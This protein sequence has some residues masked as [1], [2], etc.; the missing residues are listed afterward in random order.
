MVSVFGKIMHAEFALCKNYDFARL[1]YDRIGTYSANFSSICAGRRIQFE[2]KSQAEIRSAGYRPA[3]PTVART[4]TTI[5]MIKWR[6]NWMKHQSFHT[7][8]VKWS[9]VCWHKGHLRYLTD[10]IRNCGLSFLLPL[11]TKEKKL[12]KPIAVRFASPN[13]SPTETHKHD[14]SQSPSLSDTMATY[15]QPPDILMTSHNHNH[16]FSGGSHFG[17]PPTK[18]M[19]LQDISP[20]QQQYRMNGHH[21]NGHHQGNG[22]HPS[23]LPH[24]ESSQRSTFHQKLQQAQSLNFLNRSGW[25]N[26]H[27]GTVPGKIGNVSRHRSHSSTT[28][29]NEQRPLQA[30]H[31]LD[32]KQSSQPNL[33][34]SKMIGEDHVYAPISV[35]S[36]PEE[37]D[38][39]EENRILRNKVQVI[40]VCRIWSNLWFSIPYNGPVCP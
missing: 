37:S 22:Y 24:K 40:I 32:M 21:S 9:E 6:N 20:V 31:S 33:T 36:V 19:S 30:S 25:A 10:Y 2:L 11:Q 8:P 27:S 39:A 3:P 7:W 29:P 12:I 28:Y 35:S 17:K 15:A 1:K 14:S 5:D 34:S 13:T 23:T 18:A 38:L 4:L 16:G 26:F